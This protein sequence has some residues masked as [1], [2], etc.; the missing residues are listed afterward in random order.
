MAKV[1]RNIAVCAAI[2]GSGWLVAVPA[3]PAIAAGGKKPVVNVG[4]VSAV[5]TDVH[6]ETLTF[7][8]S[9]TKP[10]A[11][12]VTVKYAT[13]DGTA[14]GTA[15]RR[16]TGDYQPVSGT[17][18]FAAGV[19]DGAVKVV[20]YGDRVAEFDEQFQLTLS[21]PGGAKAGRMSGTGTILNNDGSPL[22]HLHIDISGATPRAMAISDSAELHYCIDTCDLDLRTGPVTVALDLGALFHSEM[23]GTAL[24]S[25]GGACAGAVYPACFLDFEADA[26]VSVEFVA[27][28]IRLGYGLSVGSH[29]ITGQAWPGPGSSPID[30][31]IDCS[32]GAPDCGFDLPANTLVLL[33]TADSS[34]RQWTLTGE[35]AVILGCGFSASACGFFSNTDTVVDLG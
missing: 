5:E 27:R 4:D 28:T 8:V 24:V 26:S 6:N 3:E 18:T 21:A 34:D 22:R 7:T 31:G 20:V 19:T 16:A 10:A 15:K 29:D 11:N 17:L 35:T 2:I 13:V 9:L 1:G 30:V 12:V 14:T 23:P 33:Q 25:F 32:T